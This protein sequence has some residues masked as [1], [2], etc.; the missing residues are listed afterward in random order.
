M[1]SLSNVSNSAS[2]IENQQLT[3]PIFFLSN[4]CNLVPVRLDSTHY[5]FWRF[6]VESI[7]RAHSLFGLI[8]GTI[9]CPNKFLPTEKESSSTTSTVSAVNPEFTKWIAQANALIT[10]INATLSKV[11]LSLVAK[12]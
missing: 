1:A 6:Q 12:L 3:S 10:L 4:I 5:L 2:A 9:S 7:L 11:A 8:D